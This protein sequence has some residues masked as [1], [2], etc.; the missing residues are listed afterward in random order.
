ME[1]L[2][3]RCNMGKDSG[4][5]NK[6]E[7]VFDIIGEILAVIY[8]IVFAL[9][10]IDAQWPFI[11]NVDWLYNAFKIIWQYGAFVIAAIVGLEAMVKRNFLFFLIFCILIALCVMFLFF[12]G[13]YSNLLG[14]V[15]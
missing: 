14:L 5:K 7:K 3:R 15:S 4:W 13:T 10:L 12:P 11:S 8:I 6:L 9:L 2:F 1:I